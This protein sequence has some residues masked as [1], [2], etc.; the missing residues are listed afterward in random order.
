[1]RGPDT[2]GWVY[3]GPQIASTQ[4]LLVTRPSH[5]KQKPGSDLNHVL[6]S[7]S[8]PSAGDNCT[9]PLISTADKAEMQEQQGPVIKSSY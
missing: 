1:M 5:N 7:M 8:L 6:I 9:Y 3:R 4:P 2:G